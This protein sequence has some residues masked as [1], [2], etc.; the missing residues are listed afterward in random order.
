MNRTLFPALLV[1]AA[2]PLAFAAQP[3]ANKAAATK[4]FSTTTPAAGLTGVKL[5]AGVGTVHVTTSNADSVR[6]KVA[7]EPGNHMHFIFDWTTGPSANTLPA[8]LHLV[9]RREGAQ[10]VVNLA[11]GAGSAAPAAA[12]AD[13][14]HDKTTFNINGRSY[15][16]GDNSGWKT[17]W[18][19]MLPK[20][21]ALD[22]TLGVGKADV[23]GVAGGV[24]AKVGVGKLDI[25]LPQGP[26][27]ANAGVG[28]IKAFVASADYGKVKL[29]AGVGHVEFDVNGQRNKTGY[30][31]HF[32]AAEQRVDGTGKTAYTLKSGVGD[33]KLELGVKDLPKADDDNPDDNR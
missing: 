22:L 29:T 18:T 16:A 15:T 32:T 9:T 2:T 33:V 5:T 21:L 7:A 25:A 31:K 1:L 30:E 10:L 11:T 27:N 20:R 19:V 14:G 6:I 12:S 28:K 13:S 8:G 26:I 23:N 17:D 4:T 24:H 3:S